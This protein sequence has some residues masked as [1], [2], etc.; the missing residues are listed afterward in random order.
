[1]S[2]LR[3][4]T[5]PS[6][7][8]FDQGATTSNQRLSAG[9]YEHRL[10]DDFLQFCP[11]KN[12]VDFAA[13]PNNKS[14]FIRPESLDTTKASKAPGSGDMVTVDE[15]DTDFQDFMCLRPKIIEFNGRRIAPFVLFI[16]FFNFDSK[17]ITVSVTRYQATITMMLPSSLMHPNRISGQKCKNS[18]IVY[19]SVYSLLRRTVEK[20]GDLF[21]YKIVLDLPFAAEPFLATD[22]IYN[23]NCKGIP[24]PHSYTGPTFTSEREFHQLS[25]PADFTDSLV[26]LFQEEEDNFEI[27]TTVSSMKLLSLSDSD[28]GND[29]EW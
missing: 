13:T 11:P 12:Y 22:T 19:Q 20:R 2:I 18:H 15:N 3:N 29:F 17:W 16:P 4:G 27:V 8:F 24:T 6:V 28:D 14:A 26:L 21:S 5:S 23:K 10:D 9:S 7:R 25:Q 1:M